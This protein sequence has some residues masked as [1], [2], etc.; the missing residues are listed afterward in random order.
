MSSVS[1]QSNGFISI[2]YDGLLLWVTELFL[3][4]KFNGI[5]F[6]SKL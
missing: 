1:K 5:S 2:V 4:G 3:E 6:N